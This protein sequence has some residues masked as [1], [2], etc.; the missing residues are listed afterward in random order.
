MLRIFLGPEW[1]GCRDKVRWNSWV[2]SILY[3]PSPLP[4]LKFRNAISRVS[5][6]PWPPNL[7]SM[8]FEHFLMFIRKE[9]GQTR[10]L[11]LL[12]ENNSFCVCAS[13]HAR[14]S[15]ISE[16]TYISN[17]EHDTPKTL[18][19]HI[20]GMIAHNLPSFFEKICIC[21]GCMREYVIWDQNIQVLTPE[22]PKTRKSE[23]LPYNH[24]QS[25]HDKKNRGVSLHHLQKWPRPT[26]LVPR[27]V[28]WVL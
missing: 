13:K 16:I 2:T 18:R 5:G 24:Y 17:T 28:P 11:S 1:S 19:K 15:W 27:P 22:S 25:A 20:L 6:H 7:V 12:W 10:K 21:W 8:F 4:T 23:K 14:F 26:F 3:D 9:N